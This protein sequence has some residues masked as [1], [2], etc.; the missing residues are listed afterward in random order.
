MLVY[1]PSKPRSLSSIKAW[2][3]HTASLVVRGEKLGGDPQI[4]QPACWECSQES[5]FLESNGIDP[6]LLM[7]HE[8][9]S[10]VDH[11]R[12]VWS[13][14]IRGPSVENVW[15]VGRVFSCRVYIDF[16]HHDSQI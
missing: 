11:A 15:R 12:Y 16:N 3:K 7:T 1:G 13:R 9:L 14:A 10:Y 2:L 4:G 6:N 5:L 8:R